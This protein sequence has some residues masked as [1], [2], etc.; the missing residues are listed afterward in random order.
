VRHLA[1]DGR[2]EKAL[3]VVIESNER[4]VCAVAVDTDM[5]VLF[6][7]LLWRCTAIVYSYSMVPERRRIARSLGLRRIQRS[8]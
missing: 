5:V 7:H 2:W 1:S 6:Q 3:I 4:N 8:R